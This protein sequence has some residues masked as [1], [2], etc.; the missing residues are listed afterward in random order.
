MDFSSLIV[1]VNGAW[2]RCQAPENKR[3]GDCLH[4]AEPDLVESLL[5]CERQVSVFIRNAVPALDRNIRAGIV[6]I[7]QPVE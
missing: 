5:T 7:D 4:I 3:R 6:A 2:Q 1:R